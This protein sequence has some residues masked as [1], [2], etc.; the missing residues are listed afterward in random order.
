L[1]PEA[2]HTRFVQQARWTR[3][4]RLYLSARAGI[5]KTRRDASQAM[6]ILE[7]GCGTGAILR[8]WTQADDPTQAALPDAVAHLPRQI[9]GLDIDAAHL[10]LAAQA[11]AAAHFVQGDAFRLPY[12]DHSFDLL[13][14]HFL[15]LWLGDPL[16]A[17]QE[18]KRL[19]RPGGA[20]LALAEPD[21]GGRIDYPEAL[22]QLGEWQQAALRRQ[23]AE[24]RTGRR[25]A[26]LFQTAQFA[27][28]ESGVM[29]GQWHHPSPPSPGI[30]RG[31]GGEGL[32]ENLESEWAVLSADL[33]SSQSPQT[34]AGLRALDADARRR[35]ERILFV[36]TFY[37]WGRVP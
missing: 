26:A 20:V 1:Q 14:C 21:Y 5:S 22:A 2:W 16:P 27:D 12:A 18:M 35:G 28:V 32:D 24:P 7:V 31:A 36:P 11:A 15:L 19:T 4:L 23:G 6:R 9:F 34:L 8:D 30:G 33:Q 13:Y 37:A 29:G 3:D 25:L 17:L 10:H